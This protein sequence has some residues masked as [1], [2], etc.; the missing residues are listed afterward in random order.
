MCLFALLTAL[1][2]LRKKL[3][4]TTF[5]FSS[6]FFLFSLIYRY[7]IF[8]YFFFLRHN[9]HHCHL[10]FFSLSSFL[11]PSIYHIHLSVFSFL[12]NNRFHCHLTIFF[13]SFV[14]LCCI[15][16][17]GLKAHAGSSNREKRRILGEPKKKAL[18]HN[19]SKSR[20]A[21][22]HTKINATT[23]SQEHTKPKKSPN[24]LFFLPH[25]HR[26]KPITRPRL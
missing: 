16:Y 21:R 25:P 14:V 18:P 7:D 6:F 13:L 15:Y 5:F 19:T 9:R 10:A 8:V 4:N 23:P 22:H 17:F 12:R 3:A 11:F 2:S 1:P 24:N 26:R 20:K